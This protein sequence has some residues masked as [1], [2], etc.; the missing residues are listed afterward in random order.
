MKDVEPLIW[1]VKEYIRHMDEER[2]ELLKKYPPNPPNEVCNHAF[3]TGICIE[4]SFNP[5]VNDFIP[6]FETDYEKIYLWTYK[7]N[8]YSGLISKVTP[9]IKEQPF[10]KNI[11][12]ILQLAFAF[13]K[14]FEYS[15][16]EQDY[17]WIYY[18]DP[19]STSIDECVFYNLGNLEQFSI[20]H[21]QIVKATDISSIANI[22]ELLIR[23]DKAFTALSL[24]NSS[25]NMSYC[26]LI[27]EL[28]KNPWHNHL[29]DEPEIW[30]QADILP[31]IE[32]ATVQACR[33]VESILGEP[34]KRD[35][36]SRVFNFKMKF[37]NLLGINA[38]DLFIKSGKTYLD[39]YYD[40]FFKL[41]NPSA[42]SYGDI[43]FNL[44]RTKVVEAQCFAFEI[45]YGYF[46]K[47]MDTQEDAMFKLKFNNNL[48]DRVH[49]NMST[50][51][52]K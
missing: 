30:E 43:H 27:C 10:W 6:F 32:S 22:I 47:N 26:C 29:T 16:I 5:S 44:E 39:F 3:L 18:F 36:Q 11:G 35:K 40:L 7:K 50:S 13:Y 49:P 21:G 41:R 45:L 24:L 8:Q 2:N 23:D 12:Y 17:K 14:S 1:K 25:F 37:K 34:P 38:D 28:S 19:V 31:K 9:S 4:N 42:H 48:L 46:E 51:R 20:S 15:N 52:T 33:C